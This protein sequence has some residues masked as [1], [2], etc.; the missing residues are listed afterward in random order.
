MKLDSLFLHSLPRRV[1][2]M[3]ASAV[4]TATPCMLHAALTDF[5]VES[6]T[7]GKIFKLSDA[8]GKYV[9]VHFRLK[10]ECPFCLKHTHDYAM[11]ASLLP[12]VMHVFLKP[13]SDAEIKSWT[14]K[15][16]RA[17]DSPHVAIYRDPDAK[18]AEQLKIPG[19]YQF[20]GQSVHYP[21]L[22]L[23]DPD[24]R[25]VF[26]YVGKGNSD[27]Y[28]FE[29]LSAKLAELKSKAGPAAKR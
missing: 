16:G 29:Q 5:S 11:K 10:T 19:G 20:H 28:T 22:V 23:F 2:L 8:K 7:D 3:V 17:E 13:D 26:R 15:L 1:A 12:D 14:A 4:L 21:A 24:G 25:E 9:A 27:R 18:L 6:P